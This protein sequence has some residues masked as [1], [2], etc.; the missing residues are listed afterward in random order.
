MNNQQAQ[1]YHQ[2]LKIKDTVNPSLNSDDY[3]KI[4]QY[5]QANNVRFKDQEFPPDKSSLV[6]PNI[7]RDYNGSWDH[8]QW[9]RADQIFGPGNYQVFNGISPNDIKQGSLGNC[10]F[11]CAL[12]SLAE[13]PSLIERLFDSA[14]INE[15]GVHAV[16]L[17]INGVW[18]RIVVDEYFPVVQ[19]NGKYE[20]AFSKTDQNELWVIILEKAYAKAFGSYWEIVGGDPVHALRDLTGAPYD[21]IEDFENMDEAWSHLKEANAK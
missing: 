3:N 16:W 13:Y 11:L 19:R 15:H 7:S 6:K 20:L 14:E 1:N 2:Y 5:C 21:R 9:A 17:N 12:S 4:R 8:I 10:Y 18:Q